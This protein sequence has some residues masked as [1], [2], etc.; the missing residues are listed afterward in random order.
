MV[1]AH[2]SNSIYQFVIVLNGTTIKKGPKFCFF[3]IKYE[4][5]EIVYIVLPRP[6]SSAKIPFNLLLY[7]ET[8]HLRPFN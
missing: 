7:R 6:I 1:G 5:K 4:N 3:S 8:N 2:F